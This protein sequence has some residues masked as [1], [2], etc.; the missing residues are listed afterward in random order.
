[1]LKLSARQKR[2]FY[3]V[4]NLLLHLAIFIILLLTLNSCAQAEELPEADCGTLATVK[5]LTGLDGCGFVLELDNGT[6]LE[7][8]IPA[9]NTNGQT[10]PLQNFPLTDGQRVSVSYQVRQ[11]IG[12]YCMVGTIVE[13][14]CIETVA[15]PSENT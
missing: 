13:I 1:M 7:S 12:S 4:S 3:S 8:Y 5:N 6:R 15:A 9:Q 10:S 2:E 14:T 11:D